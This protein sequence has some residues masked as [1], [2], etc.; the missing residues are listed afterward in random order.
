LPAVRHILRRAAFALA[1]VVVLLQQPAAAQSFAF[2]ILERY[3]EQLRQHAGIPGMSA[4]VVYDR[5]IAWRHGFGYSQLETFIAARDDTPYLIGDLTQTFASVLLLQC[6]ERGT[7]RLDNPTA[8][9]GP[10]GNVLAHVSSPFGNDFRYDPARF[11]RLTPIVDGCGAESARLRVARDVFDKLTMRDSVPGR[12]LQD[13]TSI[14]RPA[15]TPSQLEQ[16]E[17]ALARLA[18]PYQV[19][20]RGRATRSP[21]PASRL[22]ASDGLVA[23]AQDLGKYIAELRDG[24]ILLRQDTIDAMWSNR[25]ASGAARPTG[26]GWFVQQYNG[27]RLVWHFGLIPDAYSSLILSIPSKKLT[28]ILLANSDGLSASFDLP[29]G[30][31]T[32]SVFALAFLRLF[33]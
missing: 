13:V 30:D 22:D 25:T 11:A 21:L 32:R 7:L 4:V 9:D 26:L 28:L 16:Y 27:E 23:S 3:F 15:F 17:D 29:Q 6:V 10:I 18:M 8:F 14:A 24:G 1:V 33:L 5:D 31:V 2:S 20:R 12:D 19:D